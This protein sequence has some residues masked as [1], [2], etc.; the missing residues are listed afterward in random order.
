MPGFHSDTWSSG[1]TAIPLYRRHRTRQRNSP[2]S[3]QRNLIQY[4]ARDLAECKKF[5]PSPRCCIFDV[6]NSNRLSLFVEVL[7]NSNEISEALPVISR[8]RASKLVCKGTYNVL[9]N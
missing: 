6:V 3:E 9:K 2:S 8:N 1:G 5:S 4:K 7:C